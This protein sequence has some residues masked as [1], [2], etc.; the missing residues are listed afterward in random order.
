MTKPTLYLMLGL[1]GAGK[2]TASKIIHQLTGAVHLWADQERRELFGVP[3]YSHDENLDLYDQLNSETTSLLSAG[4][5]VVYDTNF[6]F[7]KDRELMR[8]IANQASAEIKLIWVVAAQKLAEERATNATE[9]H[10]S[11]VLGD[12]NG[13]MPL[14]KFRHIQANFEAPHDNEDYIELDGTKITPDYVAS[15]L[16]L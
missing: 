13:N 14:Q 9:R 5:S 3:S 10:P 4:K 12:H 6:G 1:P 11:R 16:G 15:K 7:Y 2:T 8:S